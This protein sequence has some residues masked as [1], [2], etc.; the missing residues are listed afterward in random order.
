MKMNNA[1][2]VHMETVARTIV[3][4]ALIIFTLQIMPPLVHLTENMIVYIWLIF[5]SANIRVDIL[6]K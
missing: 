3:K 2:I 6:R 4:V 5:M 1:K